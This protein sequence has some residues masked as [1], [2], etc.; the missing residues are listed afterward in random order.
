MNIEHRKYYIKRVKTNIRNLE[1]S[2]G[3]F[4]SRALTNNW[5]VLIGFTSYSMQGLRRLG[6][7]TDHKNLGYKLD[8][9]AEV[10]L[11]LKII[12]D[13]DGTIGRLNYSKQ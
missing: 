11:A 3:V 9:M 5:S 4:N 2:S 10:R 1:R 8:P 13:S 7:T 6:H 12:D